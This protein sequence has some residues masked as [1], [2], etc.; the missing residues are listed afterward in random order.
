MM[1]PQAIRAEALWATEP[2]VADDDFD[3]DE[4]RRS[5]RAEGLAT[6]KE[7]VDYVVDLDAAGV[8]CRLYRP[9]PNAAV[10]VHLHGGGFVFGDLET[11]DAH[12]RRLALATGWAVLSVDYR[13]APEHRYPAA[14]DDV[15]TVVDWLRQQGSSL[16]VDSGRL[17]VMGDSAGGQLALVACLRRP[18][19]SASVL[20][21][22][23]IDPSGSYPSY[24]SETGG[25]TGAEMD[26]YWDAYAPAASR[27]DSR[28]LFPLAAGA[29]LSGLP[30]TMVIT[31]EHD[32][33][34]DEGEALAAAIAAAGVPS[35]SVRYLGMIHGF[36]G[37]PELFD[38][39]NVAVSQVS[40]WLSSARIGST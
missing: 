19:F 16:D 36:F 26:W 38:A 29:D 31:A 33:L 22:P 30:A 32:P 7:P 10:I 14:S 17:S 20:V 39:S 9:R 34:R 40:A 1:H 15:D 5:S 25:L 21:Y 12:C 28:E 37:D 35:V 27:S 24:R 6:A 3:I 2:S 11:H 8:G 13:R 18:V 23:C 4:Q